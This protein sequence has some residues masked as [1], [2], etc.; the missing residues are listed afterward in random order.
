MA[1]SIKGVAINCNSICSTGLVVDNVMRANV[2]R[3]GV[4]GQIGNCIVVTSVTNNTWL[5]AQ[6]GGHFRDLDC[7]EAGAHG[8]GLAVG[9]TVCTTGNCVETVTNDLFENILV[10][11]DASAGSTACGLTLGFVPDST[12]IN[13]NVIDLPAGS[14]ANSI[15]ISPP[16]GATQY[17][18]NLTFIHPRIAG[19]LPA[20]PRRRIDWRA[21][22]TIIGWDTTFSAFP[23]SIDL[24]LWHGTDAGG[25][26]YPSGTCSLTDGSGAALVFTTA[27]CQWYKI[28][29]R[30]YVSYLV[31]YPSTADTSTSKI[32]GLPCTATGGL[33]SP[34]GQP[35]AWTNYGAMQMLVN[36]SANTVQPYNPT[37]GVIQNSALSGK[38][39]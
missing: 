36:S 15:C 4:T 25:S 7:S 24:K 28:G 19:P 22:F 3:I 6:E 5:G 18:D 39:T 16:P 12:F 10:D 32:S 1:L 23:S 11:Y 34:D 33:S 29:Q 38:T 30:C 27:A 13:L 21:G 14:A 2:E 26:V 17:P 37:G 20:D 31:A 9:D 35:P 8:G